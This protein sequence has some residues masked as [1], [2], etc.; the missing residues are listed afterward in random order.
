MRDWGLALVVVVGVF[1]GYTLIFSPPPPP[2]GKIAPDFTLVDLD[3]ESRQLSTLSEEVVIL[4]FW[5]TSCDPCRAEIPELSAFAKEHP[6]VGLYGIS[7]DTMP[8]ERLKVAAKRLGVEYTVLHDVRSDVARRYGI[9]VFPTTLVL[10]D[11]EVIEARVGMLNQRELERM[12][13]VA[14]S[15]EHEGHV[16]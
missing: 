8:R 14:M 13:S 11:Q 4:N 9:Q 10:R 6:E 16:H 15:G 5:F 7:T 1:I 2:T 12:V 3:G